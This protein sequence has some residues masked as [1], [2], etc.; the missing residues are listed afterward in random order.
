MTNEELDQLELYFT[1]MIA[2]IQRRHEQELKPWVDRVLEIHSVRSLPPIIMRQ[3]PPA[4]P[5]SE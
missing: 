1:N 3:A 4:E 2:D 5:P